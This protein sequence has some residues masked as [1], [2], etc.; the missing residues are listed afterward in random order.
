VEKRLLTI[1]I[2]TSFIIAL[3][4]ERDQY[5]SQ[6]L[7]LADRY[8][9]QAVLIT[10]AVLLEIANSLARRYKNEAVQVIE[11]FLASENVAVIRLTPDIFDRSF[12]LYKTRPDKEWGLVDCV[13][14]IVMRDR[15]VHN[16]LTFDQHFTQAGFQRLQ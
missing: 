16:V 14:F 10:D 7:D 5:H 9:D 15:D 13:S 2:D 12:E 1:F 11:E 3:I 4:N 8:I 6:A